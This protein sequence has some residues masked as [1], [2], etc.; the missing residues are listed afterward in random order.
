MSEQD[1]WTRFAEHLRETGEQLFAGD[2][3]DDPLIRAEG[4]RYLSRLTRLALKQYVEAADT[5]FP[6][7]YRLSHETAKIGADNPDSAYL[8]ATIDGSKTYRI[9]GRRGTMKY[10]SIVANAMRYDTDGTAAPTGSLGDGEIDWG[11][12]GEVEIIAS[13]EEQPGNWLR[14]EPDANIIIIRQNAHDRA[15]ETEGRFHIEQLGGPQVPAPL[16]PQALAAGLDRAA[17]FVRGVANTFAGWTRMFAEHPNTF[18]DFDQ[19]IYQRAGGSPDL[20]YAHAYW[21][22]APDEAWVIEVTPPDCPYW[23][24]QLNN[25]WMESFDYRHRKVT[26]NNADAVLEPDGSLKIVCAARDP[27]VGNWIDTCGH[28]QGT[29]LLRWSHAKENPLPRARVVKLEELEG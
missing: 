4:Q 20:F 27:A 7:F 25:W 18:H 13:C 12:D 24:F 8:N 16:D 17:M 10:F 11:L 19:A 21:N 23:N 22:L 15:N 2:V 6:F 29:A 14:L 1:A 28:A 26:V 9:T 3:P 5:D